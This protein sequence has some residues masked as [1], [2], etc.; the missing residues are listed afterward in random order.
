MS[1][2][3]DHRIEHFT[4]YSLR[5][6]EER[7]TSLGKTH[8][9]AADAICLAGLAGLATQHRVSHF[10][11]RGKVF[12]GCNRVWGDPDDVYAR[13]LELDFLSECIPESADFSRAAIG[14]SLGIEEHS[15]G[16]ALCTRFEL[17][18]RAIGVGERQDWG[19][20]VL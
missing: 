10:V 16:F 4:Y 7:D 14:T 19:G 12:D 3:V 2:E 9:T 11:F 6:D 13:V 18:C 5:V 20:V 8:Q 1:V 17:V 15:G